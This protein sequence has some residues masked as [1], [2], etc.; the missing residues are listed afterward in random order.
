[1]E[2][3]LEDCL[4]SEVVIIE[5]RELGE[6]EFGLV[7]MGKGEI[8]AHEVD[9]IFLGLY[10]VAFA[11]LDLCHIEQEGSDSLLIAVVGA[12]DLDDCAKTGFE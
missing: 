5:E 1:M 12:D 10:E 6:Q 11:A 8:E 4:V 9:E 3:I 2:Q 7:V